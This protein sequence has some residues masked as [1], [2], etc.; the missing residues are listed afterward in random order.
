MYKDKYLKYKKKYLTLKK[1]GSGEK[2]KIKINKMSKKFMIVIDNFEFIILGK[3]H[4]ENKQRPMVV[5]SSK[6]RDDIK[7]KKFIV[8]RSNSQGYWRYYRLHKLNEPRILK[9]DL[10]AFKYREITNSYTQTTC[11]HHLL[12]NFLNKNYEHCNLISFTDKLLKEMWEDKIAFYKIFQDYRRELY[13]LCFSIFDLNPKDNYLISPEIHKVLCVRE[14]LCKEDFIS[15]NNR[16]LGLQKNFFNKNIKNIKKKDYKSFSSNKL[17]EIIELKLRKI[18]DIQ[19]NELESYLYNMK[20][21]LNREKVKSKLGEDDIKLANTTINTCLKWFYT[22]GDS[23]TLEELESKKKEVEEKLIPLMTKLYQN[24]GMPGNVPPTGDTNNQSNDP[25]K[26]LSSIEIPVNPIIKDK[27]KDSDTLYHSLFE[28][29][30]K[31]NIEYINNI[32]K[33][34]NLQYEILPDTLIVYNE[35]TKIYFHNITHL[36]DYDDYE[37]KLYSIKLKNRSHLAKDTIFEDIIIIFSIIKLGNKEFTYNIIN[38]ISDK[39][40]INEYGVYDKY[41]IS[42]FFCLKPFEYKK[43]VKERYDQ[44]LTKINEKNFYE[45]SKK[46]IAVYLDT[47]KVEYHVPLK[48]LYKD[49]KKEKEIKQNKE[50]YINETY[51]TLF[52]M[53]NKLYPFNILFNED[54]LFNKDIEFD[55]FKDI[56]T[57]LKNN[58]R[59]IK[60]YSDKIYST[61]N[62]LINE[63]KITNLREIQLKYLEDLEGIIYYFNYHKEYN[64][65]LD[66]FKIIKTYKIKEIK[67]LN[68]SNDLIIEYNNDKKIYLFKKEKKIGSGALGNVYSYY[69]KD[70]EQHYAVKEYNN[71]H[72]LKNLTYLKFF[73]EYQM[74][75]NE[76][77]YTYYSKSMKKLINIMP[78]YDGD[79]SKYKINSIEEKNSLI[80][81]LVIQNICLLKI[82]L[83]LHQE[84]LNLHIEKNKLLFVYFDFKPRNILYKKQDGKTKFNLGDI[85]SVFFN[86]FIRKDEFG[87]DYTNYTEKIW[88]P[89]TDRYTV[90]DTS[91]LKNIKEQIECSFNNLVRVLKKDMEYTYKFSPNDKDLTI[92]F[93]EKFDKYIKNEKLQITLKN[94]L[95]CLDTIKQFIE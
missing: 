92:N 30:R 68:D 40:K 33:C 59:L 76:Y 65:L 14:N 2:K 37:Q 50:R 78:L 94:L 84:T 58:S 25:D 26:T 54:I 75:C 47:K 61:T 21:I 64:M 52:K 57:Y 17:N 18:Y 85:D 51:S 31:K 34:I 82:N 66:E 74:K 38:I 36:S 95:E 89:Y 10:Y 48:N 11:I 43:Q 12:N 63:K 53:T 41:I 83:N 80:K 22:K 46:K 39:C 60:E 88:H 28:K 15:Y 70:L 73:N 87:N 86:I 24:A 42:P 91:K 1:I 13:D 79:L 62:N 45:D 81:S 20:N 67:Y 77:F 23:A 19:R 71:L 32:N 16:S 3:I 4:P 49:I 8:Y 56:E 72:F 69:N 29:S 5:I 7:Y 90:C 35:K 6:H 93:E 55:S 27:Y 44:F 9:Q